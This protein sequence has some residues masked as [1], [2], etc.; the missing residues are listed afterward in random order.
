VAELFVLIGRVWD[1]IE[2]QLSTTFTTQKFQQILVKDAPEVWAVLVERYGVGGKGSGNFYSPN[3]ILFN[4]LR[5]RAW[6]GQLVQ[7]GSVASAPGWGTGLVMSW[8]KADDATVPP[9]EED[10]EQV[11]GSS[12]FRSHFVRERAPGIR[13]KLLAQRRMVGLSCDICGTGGEGY[14][15]ELR[16]AIFEAHHATKPIQD[17]L[18]R[19][20]LKDMALLCA[21]C[22]RLLHRLV[23]LR[24]EW[25]TVAEAKLYIGRDRR[26]ESVIISGK[27]INFGR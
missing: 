7:A 9:T 18:R 19:T 14:D 23:K 6:N 10:I 1:G 16:D 24:K 2:T 3:N 13:K 11:E 20:R 4:F 27:A 26:A 8:Q 15:D 12:I 21:C 25:V 17:G 5:D 22:H